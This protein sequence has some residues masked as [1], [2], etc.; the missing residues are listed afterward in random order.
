MNFDDVHESSHLNDLNENDE[1]VVQLEHEFSM[2]ERNEREK[3]YLSIGN[4]LN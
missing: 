1:D 4:T 2:Q 3:S